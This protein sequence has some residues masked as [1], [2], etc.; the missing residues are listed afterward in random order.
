MILRTTL[1]YFDGARHDTVS[2][3]GLTLEA[4]REERDATIRAVR[5]A[6]EG[7]GVFY[8]KSDEATLCFPSELLSRTH[9]KLEIVEE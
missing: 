7:R 8:L 2:H 3:S 5:E 9:I 6:V 4:A 1:T